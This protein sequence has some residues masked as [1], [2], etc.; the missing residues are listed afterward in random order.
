MLNRENK[1]IT[2]RRHKNSIKTLIR[3]RVQFV[4]LK[5][6]NSSEIWVD[7][8]LGGYSSLHIATFHTIPGSN[9]GSRKQKLQPSNSGL[10]NKYIQFTLSVYQKE[11]SLACS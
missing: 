8:C 7:W 1:Y 2:I 3:K 5:Y 9:L 10:G 11:I 6:E 4:R